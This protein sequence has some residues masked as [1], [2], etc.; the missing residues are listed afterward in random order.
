MAGS[1]GTIEGRDEAMTNCTRIVHKMAQQIIVAVKLTGEV[2]GN[3]G[4]MKRELKTGNM[5]QIE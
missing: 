3:Q 1:L 2:V 5:Y 4:P